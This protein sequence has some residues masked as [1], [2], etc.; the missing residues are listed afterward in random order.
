MEK[1]YFLLCFLA[2]IF[3]CMGMAAATA[4]VTIRLLHLRGR[5]ELFQVACVVF[6]LWMCISATRLMYQGWRDAGTSR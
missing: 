2:G 4:V 6:L 3:A 5:P 1:K